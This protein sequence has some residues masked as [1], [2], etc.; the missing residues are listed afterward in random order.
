[1]TDLAA[2]PA[3]MLPTGMAVAWHG[4]QPP[5]PPDVLLL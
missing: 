3:V 4:T 5:P 1:M 2:V